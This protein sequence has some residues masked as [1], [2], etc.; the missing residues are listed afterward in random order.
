M[1][2]SWVALAGVAMAASACATGGDSGT[3]TLGGAAIGA[4]AGAVIG[5]NVGHGDALAGALI[6]GAVGATAG[7]VKGCHDTGGCGE[8]PPNHRQ[9][10]DETTGR[11]Y[12]YDPATRR[13][14][15][16]DGSPR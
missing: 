1:R 5:T 7:A 11:Y 2:A 13:Y 12:F 6:G 9:Y 4:V 10:F 16:E 3:E 14:Y 8:G 15:W